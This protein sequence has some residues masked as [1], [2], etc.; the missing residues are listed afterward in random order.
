M[1]DRLRGVLAPAVEL[2]RYQPSHRSAA[3]TGTEWRSEW[4]FEPGPPAEATR[5]TT[6]LASDGEERRHAFDL[7]PA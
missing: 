2:A 1:R 3:G 6:T 5:L 7:P 4:K